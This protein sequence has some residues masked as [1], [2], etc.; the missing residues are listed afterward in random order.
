MQRMVWYY[1]AK[2]NWK[3][4]LPQ[5][6]QEAQL[7][8]GEHA[9]S[10]YREQGC[11]PS[12]VGEQALLAAGGEGPGASGAVRGRRFHA[13]ARRHRDV[14]PTAAASGTAGVPELAW[15]R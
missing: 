4:P 13:A 5:Y 2:P 3:Q 15:S 14:A 1:V 7:E 10:E 6:A 11:R 12:E 8:E 9:V